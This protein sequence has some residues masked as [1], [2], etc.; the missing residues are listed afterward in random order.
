[1]SV[2]VQQILADAKRLA[3]RLKDHDSSAD[4]LLSQAQ[5][6]FRQVDTMKEVTYNIHILMLQKSDII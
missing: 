4:V 6:M 5:A 1:M 2:S 3:G